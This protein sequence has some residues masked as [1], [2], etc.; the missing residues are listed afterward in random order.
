MDVRC[1]YCKAHHWI[2]ER[3]KSSIANP[4]FSTC[5]QKGQ[6]HLPLLPHPPPALQ[7]LFDGSDNQAVEFRRNIRQY[8]LAFAFTSLGVR[9]DHLVNRQGGWVF[10]ICGVLRHYIGAL[11]PNEGVSPAYAQLYIFDPQTAL[12]QRTIRN[13][14]LS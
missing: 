13:D 5:C 4:Q 8:N 9:E 7:Q 11:R 3:T 6:V 12:S 2:Q 14:N 1:P 10:R